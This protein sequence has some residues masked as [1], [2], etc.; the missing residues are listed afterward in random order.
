MYIDF[1][2][3]LV[4]AKETSRSS[5]LFQDLF[6]CIGNAYVKCFL[7]IYYMNLLLQLSRSH[8]IQSTLSNSHVMGSHTSP[9]FP[10]LPI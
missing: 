3:A 6:F 5:I 10:D 8:S 1:Y 2:I 4:N 7:W 9:L